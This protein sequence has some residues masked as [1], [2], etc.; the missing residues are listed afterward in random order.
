ME[1]QNAAQDL[2]FFRVLKYCRQTLGSTLWMGGSVR[3]KAFLL[4]QD[5]TQKKTQTY[6]HAP[7][8]IQ[9]N[10]S[11]DRAIV[12]IVEYTVERAAI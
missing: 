11:I 1:L 6:V 7:N 3:R 12:N 9:N 8:W 4:P 10:D 5:N 2:P